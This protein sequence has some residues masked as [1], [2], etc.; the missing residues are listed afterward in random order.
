MKIQAERWDP[1]DM[2]DFKPERWLVRRDGRLKFSY[3]AARSLAFG[4]RLRSSSREG[5]RH[6]EIKT[7]LVLILWNFYPYLPLR[8]LA[9][10]EAFEISKHSSEQVF[11]KLF[12]EDL[13]DGPRHGWKE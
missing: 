6:M 8:K 10:T 5:F 7:A 13:Y 2:D 11:V 9:G 12:R 1:K 4:A 3:R